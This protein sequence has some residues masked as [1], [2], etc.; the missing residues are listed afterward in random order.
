MEIYLFKLLSHLFQ[1]NKSQ[2]TI[3]KEIIEKNF[4][5]L[6]FKSNDRNLKIHNLLDLISL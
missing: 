5:Q 2:I 6:K 4:G 1:A 3:L